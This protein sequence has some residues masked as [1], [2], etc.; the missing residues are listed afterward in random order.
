MPVRDP[1]E[2]IE[3]FRV[4]FLQISGERA[5]FAE[6]LLAVLRAGFDLND[7]EVRRNRLV[8]A[9]QGLARHQRAAP[10]EEE[11]RQRAYA[12]GQGLRGGLARLSG[13]RDGGGAIPVADPQLL[14][15]PWSAPTTAPGTGTGRR[16]GST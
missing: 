2:A 13:S 16:A 9:E 1:W 7:R 15:R 6:A 14:A 8:V 11:A 5:D 3:D 10:R 4:E 12:A